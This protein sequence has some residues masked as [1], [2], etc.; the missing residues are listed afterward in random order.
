MRTL[1]RLSFGV[2]LTASGCHFRSQDDP[3]QEPRAAAAAVANIPALDR[4][5]P[6]VLESATF[7]VG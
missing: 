3:A 1:L 5:I 7:A 4:Q 2:A 6:D